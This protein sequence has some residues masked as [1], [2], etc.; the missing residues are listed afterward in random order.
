M[1]GFSTNLQELASDSATAA[2]E[3]LRQA[4]NSALTEAL[5]NELMQAGTINELWDVFRSTLRQF[6]HAVFMDSMTDS[7]RNELFARIWDKDYLE[8]RSEAIQKIIEDEGDKLREEALDGVYE[9][10]KSERECDEDFLAEIEQ[11][12]KTEMRPEIADSLRQEMMAD[13][14]FIDAVKSDLKRS[15][16]GL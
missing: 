13:Q 6:Q 2:N 14:E 1:N 9:V 12:L 11:E 8:L 16:L 7:I 3:D 10:M 15:I 4:I 5:D